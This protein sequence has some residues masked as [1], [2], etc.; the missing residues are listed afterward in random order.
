MFM[1]KPV[2]VSDAKPLARIVNESS[3]GFIFQSG[4]ATDAATAIEKAYAARGDTT[5]GER[6]KNAV[7]EKYTWEKASRVLGQIYNQP[8]DP[9]R[10][11]LPQWQD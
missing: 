4:N 11:A 5:I 8:R 1:A 2:L 9:I 10:T 7:L 3:C 6:G